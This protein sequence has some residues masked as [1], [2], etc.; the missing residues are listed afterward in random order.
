[1]LTCNNDMQ[2]PLD[3]S[4]QTLNPQIIP[5][6]LSTLANVVT[7]I[8]TMNKDNKNQDGKQIDATAVLNEIDEN[9]M[10]DQGQ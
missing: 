8:A 9:T 3:T 7:S 10:N 4:L 2:P 5:T 6:D 1:M